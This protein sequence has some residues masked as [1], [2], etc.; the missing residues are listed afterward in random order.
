MTTPPAFYSIQRHDPA[1]PLGYATGAYSDFQ[2]G[3]TR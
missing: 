2:V 1:F 3:A